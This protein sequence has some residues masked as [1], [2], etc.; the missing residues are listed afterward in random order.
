M[1]QKMAKYITYECDEQCAQT[2]AFIEEAG[3][4][5]EFRDLGKDPMSKDEISKLL[6]YL[7]MN[8]FVNPMSESYT[9]LG[10]DKGLPDREKVLE[11]MAEDNTLLKRPI[12]TT[13][14][15]LMI[16]ND[17]QK[18]SAMLQLSNNG[19]T[20][21]DR[22]PANTNNNRGKGGRSNSRTTTAAR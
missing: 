2:R 18:I 14:R 1:A 6:G 10:F 16:G 4:L 3:V 11:A 15:L 19:N 17:K 21:Q 13:I 9:R 22:N 5:L 8:H 12:I 20:S 7:N